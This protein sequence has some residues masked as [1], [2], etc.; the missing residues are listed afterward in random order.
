MISAYRH[1]LIQRELEYM[2]SYFEAIIFLRVAKQRGF[3]LLD[4]FKTRLPFVDK[5]LNVRIQIDKVT[6]DAK[7][8]YY[9]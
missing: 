5:Q 1:S 3:S 6:L 4:R 7:K 8:T 9:N 2:P